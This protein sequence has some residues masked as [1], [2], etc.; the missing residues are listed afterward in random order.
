MRQKDS[1][2]NF[3]EGIC[4][5]KVNHLYEAQKKTGHSSLDKFLKAHKMCS[6]A[7]FHAYIRFATL[8]RRLGWEFV[9]SWPV[10]WNWVSSHLS[11]LQD[12]LDEV[13]AT[14]TLGAFQGYREQI[15]NRW[16]QENDDDGNE[17][18]EENEWALQM[19]EQRQCV[20]EYNEQ[21]SLYFETLAT[22]V[23][24]CVALS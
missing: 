7:T 22:L 8:C 15:S 11:V 13:L 3:V 19:F 1:S 4:Y 5:D 12:A 20:K 10:I 21:S 2:Y 14:V 23:G 17:R 18:I 9:C 24:E 16:V 6:K